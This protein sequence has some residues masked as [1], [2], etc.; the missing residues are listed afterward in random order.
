MPARKF[1]VELKLK[2]IIFKGKVLRAFALLASTAGKA[3][4]SAAMST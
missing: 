2:I 3:G 1:T 4:S